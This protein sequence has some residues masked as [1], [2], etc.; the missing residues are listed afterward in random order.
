MGN[1]KSLGAP[2]RGHLVYL[3]AGSKKITTDGYHPQYHGGNGIISFDYG[4]F[5]RLFYYSG[6][7]F[8]AMGLGQGVSNTKK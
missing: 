7:N 4:E 3:G 6:N 1:F 5:Q 8:L 2:G